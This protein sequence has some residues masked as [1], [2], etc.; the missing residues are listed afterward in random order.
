MSIRAPAVRGAAGEMLCRKLYFML[1]VN[2]NARYIL[3][4]MKLL[5]AQRFAHDAEVSPQ[6]YQS[7]EQR[8][9]VNE[10]EHCVWTVGRAAMLS[11]APMAPH[12]LT[13]L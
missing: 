11:G 7:V 5:E 9:S 3:C 10:N 13:G 4:A 2:G 6:S 12:R 8:R 1:T